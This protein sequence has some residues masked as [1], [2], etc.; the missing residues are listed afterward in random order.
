MKLEMPCSAI[1]H[2]RPRSHSVFS[3]YTSAQMGPGGVDGCSV[4]IPV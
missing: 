4:K 1:C 2:F 3:F